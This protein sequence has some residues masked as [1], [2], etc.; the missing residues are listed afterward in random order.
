VARSGATEIASVCNPLLP[1][2]CVYIV[3]FSAL[4]WCVY[5][6]W[7]L[8]ALSILVS[9][10][11]T[12]L[13]SFECLVDAYLFPNRP[14]KAYSFEWGR[15]KSISWLTAFLLSFAESIILIQPLKVTNDCVSSFVLCTLRMIINTRCFIAV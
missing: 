15:E 7:F 14:Y 13:Y 8:V 9:A 5:I 6:A 10:F 3:H 12:I 11:F 1:Y 4:Q 2:W